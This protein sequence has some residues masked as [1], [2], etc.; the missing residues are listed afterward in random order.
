MT[1]LPLLI[2]ILI[3]LTIIMGIALFSN[4]KMESEVDFLV[5]GRSFNLWLTTFCL[6]STWFGAGTLITATDEIAH[7]G[8]VSTALEPYGAGMCLILAGLFMAKPLWDLQLL[9]FS[10][11][12][13][14][15]FGPKA[16]MVTVL[17]TVPSYVGW[18]AV[19]LIAMAQ[20]LSAFF[21]LPMWV[22]I[23]IV[24]FISLFLTITGGIW[25]VSL[26]DSFQL[27]IIVLGL[28]YL[29]FRI[30]FWGPLGLD[31]L[32]AGIPKEYW[33]V[34]PQ[35]KLSHTV[36]WFGVFCVSALGNIT[37]QD[38]GQRIFSAK[39]AHIAKMGALIAGVG[40]MLVGS[41][42]VFFGLTAF[43]TLGAN[44][45]GSVMP[46]LIKNYLDPV[47]MVILML[48]IL[49][50]VLSTIT[51][52]LLA[53]ASVLAHN[54]LKKYFQQISTLL[55]CRYAVVLVTLMSLA[56]AFMGSDVYGLLESSYAVGLVGFFAPLFIGLT[57][58][59]LNETSCLVSMAAGLLFWLPDFFIKTEWPMALF[60]TIMS[61]VAYYV[62]YSFF[63][64]KTELTAS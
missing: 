60:G 42:P 27:V 48:T 12:Y 14:L 61:F 37:G 17:M 57:S 11:F 25:S 4:G 16:E 20:I 21:P 31:A 2:A 63:R 35:D 49:A 7:K 26:T 44:F 5:G 9:T 43:Q 39:S 55:L 24:A 52:A 50:A 62:H 30:A 19:Q 32:I 15:K 41:L 13:R 3:F 10:D 1:H 58:K 59:K 6:F 34:I 33:V 36:Q 8:L 29:F 40:Y 56:I 38:L 64:K 46:M 51:S 45:K 54:L 23:V 53:P 28:I 18:I 47:S 22:F